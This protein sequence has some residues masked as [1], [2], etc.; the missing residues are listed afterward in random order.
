ML[1]SSSSN[2]PFA[3]AFGPTT[4]SRTAS[5]AS[6]GSDPFAPTKAQTTQDDW[7]VSSQSPFKART[8]PKVD[9]VRMGSKAHK[10]VS[11]RASTVGISVQNTF[12][13]S[14]ARVPSRWP[15]VGGRPLGPAL[16]ATCPGWVT[17]T[18]SAPGRL[19]SCPRGRARAHQR[20]QV[21]YGNHQLN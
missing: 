6:A 14:S 8:P 7:F 3:A 4:N 11:E 13:S 17:P 16:P 9:G 15:P 2:D 12:T 20:C 18:R 10:Q 5:A 1:F 21:V 19:P